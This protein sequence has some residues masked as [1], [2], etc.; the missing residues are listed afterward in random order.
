MQ[1][2]DLVSDSGHSAPMDEGRVPRAPCVSAATTNAAQL[3]EPG[4]RGLP[5]MQS[6]EQE[7]QRQE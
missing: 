1:G 4:I 2:R 5:W 7:S 3:G 6:A